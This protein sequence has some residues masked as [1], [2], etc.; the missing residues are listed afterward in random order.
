MRR[1]R[2]CASA[3]ALVFSCAASAQQTPVVDDYD[4]IYAPAMVAPEATTAVLTEIDATT[5]RAVAVGDYGVIVTRDKN[6]SEWQQAEVPTSVF[7]TSVD[8]A[9]QDIGWAVGH[10][11][12]ILKTTD[13]GLTWQRQLDGFAYIEL[14]ISFFETYVN[15]LESRLA[16]D[17]LDAEQEA[18]LEFML[19]EALFQLDNAV[20]AQEEGPTKPFLDVLALSKD[21]LY[22]SGAY[23]ALLYSNDGG[24]SWQIHDTRVEN[25]DGF[26]LNALQSDGE[27]LYLAGEAGQL[28]RSDDAG[29]SWDVLDSPYY[30]SFFGMHVDQQKRLWI[31]GLRGN[32]F[33]SDDQGLSFTQLKLDDPVNINTAI[34]APDN[35]LYFV[36]NAGVVAYL[37]ATGELQ[38]RTHQSGAALTDMVINADGQLTLVGQRGVLSMPSFALTEK[39]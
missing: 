10:H 8:F 21:E 1:T 16:N 33:V 35:G 3:V 24:E 29:A 4:V 9:N 25:P 36:G 22:V 32:I 20:F 12:V 15:E 28:F 26:H 2:V 23:G 39:E 6:S 18:D 7:L 34:D 11:G 17:N 13:G 19:D 37:S 38:E 5:E 14:Q 27:M 30:G 31:Y